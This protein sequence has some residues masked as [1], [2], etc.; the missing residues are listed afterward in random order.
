MVTR[1]LPNPWH[2]ESNVAADLRGKNVLLLKNVCRFGNSS[3]SGTRLL[4]VSGLNLARAAVS[5][6]LTPAIQAELSRLSNLADMGA[7]QL[8][9]STDASRRLRVKRWKPQAAAGNFPPF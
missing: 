7:S 1:Q 3:V 2:D 6:E 5:C 9:G 4:Q 8:Y